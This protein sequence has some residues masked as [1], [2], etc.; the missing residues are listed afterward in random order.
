MNSGTMLG[1]GMH[2]WKKI[3][4]NAVVGLSFFLLS[5]TTTFAQVNTALDVPFGDRD[6]VDIVLSILSWILGILA[7]LAAVIIVYGGIVWMTSQGVAEKVTRAKAILLNAVIGLVIVLSAWGVV[8]YFMGVFT[9]IL[10][11]GSGDGGG[12]SNCS[13]CSIPSSGSS[14]YVLATYPEL[15]DEE[16]YLCTDISV[17]MSEFVDPSTVT[18]D[19]FFLQIKDGA[20]N[21]A[22]CSTNNACSSGVCSAEGQCV[23]DHV[24]GQIGF[25]PGTDTKYF[26]FVPSSDLEIDTVY[27]GVV[28]G[29][30][31]GVLSKDGN[32]ADSIDDRL[33]M[34][35]DYTWFFSTGSS[36]DTLPPT[37]K[38]ESVFPADGE[39]NVCTNTVINF[40]FSEPMRITSFNDDT[41]FLLDSAGTQ[42][43]PITP[44]W[45]D[46][47]D[48]KNWSFGGDFDYVQVRPAQ[49]L[50]TFSRYGVRLS[51][52]DAENLFAGAVMDACGNALDGD[53]D[54]TSEGSTVDNYIGFTEGQTEDPITW[55][56]G[57]NAFCEP[58]IESVTQINGYYGEDGKLRDGESCSANDQCGSGSC[59][60]GICQGY[61]STTVEINGLYLAPHPE[62]RFEGSV[63]WAGESFN[64]CFNSAHLGNVETNTTA[65][66]VCLDDEIQNTDKLVLRTPV[67][68]GD[69]SVQVAVAEDFSEPS[70]GIVDVQSPHIKAI[71]PDNGAIGQYITILGENF[72]GSVGSVV[73]VSA[74]N[75]R[76]SVV[77]FPAA[78]GNV[79]SDTE[80]LVVVPETFT[81]ADGSQGTWQSGDVA[82]FQVINASNGR[83]SDLQ[84][85]TFNDVVRP[86]LCDI[87]PSCQDT[88]GAAFTLNGT[89]F[90]DS[91]SGSEVA[92]AI[93]N[94]NG[95]NGDID[96]WSDSQI[97]GTTDTSMPQEE[98][99][100]TVYDDETGLNSNGRTFTI[101]C[102]VG[103]SVV[104]LLTCAP[105]NGQYPYPNPQ[106]GAQNACVNTS[107]GVLFDQKMAASSLNASTVTLDQFNKGSSFDSTFT[108]LRVAGLIQKVNAAY[109][110]Q[111]QTYY[112]MTFNVTSTPVDADQNGVADGGTSSY[113]QP[114]TWYQLTITTGATNEQGISLPSPYTLRFKSDDTT[115]LCQIDN[116]EVQ[117]TK[118]VHNSYW[119]GGDV[120][121]TAY[122]AQP[123]TSN[124]QLLDGSIYA[125]D[126]SIDD[127]S[128]GNFGNAESSTDTQNVYVAGQTAENE[129][130]ATV[131]AKVEAESDSGEFKVDLGFC[132]ADV[133]CANV[134]GG[135]TCNLETN[136]CTPVIN[137]ITPGDGDHG[138]WVTVSGC[139]FGGTPGNAY[140]NSSNDSISAQTA[141]PNADV[142]GVTWEEDQIIVEVPAKYD[143]N[144][145]GGIDTDLPEG[146]YNIK[147]E[148]RY[149]DSTESSQTFT[150]N[151]TKRPGIC[152]ILANKGTPGDVVTAY[153][154]GLGD[155]EGLA[156]FLT[157][158]DV[159]Q[160]TGA[161]RVS[162]DVESTTWT[163]EKITTEVPI[164]IDTSSSTQG[165][166]GFR[167][168]PAGGN[169][170]CADGSCSNPVDFIASCNASS[171]CASGCCSASGICA[172]AE[173]CNICVTDSDCSK[174]GM[175]DGSTCS[176][177]QCTPVVTSIVQDAAPEKSPVTVNG[178][179]FGSY[180]VDK[181]SVTFGNNEAALLC[182]NYWSNNTI[183]A[184]VPENLPLSTINVAV[185]NRASITSPATAN[186]DFTVTAQCA[187]GGTIPAAGIPLL[188]DLF[189]DTGYAESQNGLA[190][191]S[192]ITFKGDHFTATTQQNIFSENKVGKNFTAFPDNN[193]KTTADVPYQTQSGPAHVEVAADTGICQSNGLEFGV[194]CLTASDCAEDQ[195]CIDGICS[196]NACGGC[197]TGNADQ[198]CGQ[199]QG[200]YTSTSGLSCCS[201]KP[202]LVS[203]SVKDG[204]SGVCLNSL[205]TV[206]FSE[207]MVGIPEGISIIEVTY[208]NLGKIAT[209]EAFPTT[210]TSEDGISFSV[211]PNAELKPNTTYALKILSDA[212][213]AVVGVTSS[214]T[215]LTLLDGTHYIDFRTAP[216]TCSPAEIKVLSEENL[217]NEDPADD[218]YYTFTAPNATTAFTASMYSSDGQLLAPT[219]DMGWEFTWSPYFDEASCA[220]IAWVDL[221]PE[222][223]Q[224]G[225]PSA[226]SETQNI[227][228]GTEHNEDTT[229]SVQAKPT[230]GSSWTGTLEGSAA[231]STFFCEESEVWQY[232]DADPDDLLRQNFR[233]IYCD[234]ASVPTLKEPTIISG[235]P[236]D[237]FFRQYLFIDPTNGKEAFGIRVY[238]NELNLTPEQWYALNVPNPGSPRGRTVDGYQ[239]LQD[240]NS[241]YVAAS[242]IID[243]QLYNNI[244][245]ITFSDSSGIQNI[246]EEILNGLKFNLGVDHQQC[247]ASDKEKLVRDTKRVNDIGTISYLA[248]QYYL[249]NGHYP[250]PKSESFSS[251]L[252]SITASVWNSWQGALGNQLGET[253]PTDP[254]NFFYASDTDNPSEADSTPW[255]VMGE[256]VT[257]VPD[258]RYD[259][260]NNQYYDE[261]GTCWDSVN[262]EFFCPENSHTYLWKINPNNLDD[263][264]DAYLYARLEY[265]SNSTETYQNLD[266]VRNNPCDNVPNADCQCYN[267]GITSENSP[268]RLPWTDIP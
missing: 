122:N 253:L 118:D 55:T 207:V 230:P 247:E 235:G 29:G 56:T 196:E 53:E 59:S 217:K 9:D 224:S 212:N 102:N 104:E 174:G 216:N 30:G 199:D 95:Y 168:I 119:E 93:D 80:V 160:P 82:Y 66:D 4:R 14:F 186:S 58:V 138:T 234:T 193:T 209:E 16:V 125:W 31:A 215:Q 111:G 84:L 23:G 170:Q 264:D 152:Q 11:T 19:T 70:S 132:T 124:C 161:D 28:V 68:S 109:D 129:G 169:D 1:S 229:L 7:L 79:W 26:N 162:A 205:F 42:D 97:T 171:D 231:L 123:Y 206:K 243:T 25:G 143:T 192:T 177:G 67:G 60:A 141:W 140:W 268:G 198:V 149:R 77:E 238:K 145:D 194:S 71:D 22:A 101:P 48:L 120:A 8:L 200:C 98:Y 72:G 250:R 263:A 54:Q 164:G 47:R 232:I 254:F 156:S 187:A 255:T 147:I 126:W 88:A 179:Y 189:P 191:G 37:V 39:N 40:D 3:L 105:E 87:V 211:E 112:G 139:M 103:P 61:P 51:G 144:G 153:G 226:T 244:Y 227:V 121:S 183:I 131:T 63:N 220:N 260:A 17:R 178:C 6:L 128:I 33:A 197:T 52:G 236:N 96:N 181:S 127:T 89:N 249:K 202:Q 203:T 166:D 241:Y 106:Q 148:T 185:T 45:T 214:A 137:S 34:S 44:D 267:Y 221:T 228:S 163:N 134:C 57:E 108:S 43:N 239:A 99:W 242:N 158:Q 90:G 219:T 159:I 75:Q 172:P 13:G 262:E 165:H 74:D 24:P 15:A 225:L 21:G 92:F 233:L 20:A 173:S 257:Q 204:A 245:L 265:Q 167:A 256:E 27:E 210:L 41:S 266:D 12:G 182:N 18:N 201:V 107:I 175:C 35:T 94:D 208:D 246:S 154:Q 155:T 195:F 240:G 135:S 261:A 237:D 113:L 81:A 38:A 218:A 251:Y 32:T 258:C 5:A 133:D 130:T 114:D 64:T 50:E 110:A 86:N 117:P 151:Q 46:T 150:V 184:E 49:T 136:H 10:G 176:S 69:T 91:R 62:V 83:H 85:F 65:G 73:L 76:R 142:C 100:V 223:D 188:C 248:N 252:D 2:K 115:E 213:S 222:E 190:K 78:C 180:E 116:L 36:T 259:P 157:A 146:P